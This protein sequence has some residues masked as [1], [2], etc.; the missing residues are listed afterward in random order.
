MGEAHKAAQRAA[1]HH[2]SLFRFA[3]ALGG[4]DQE[5]AME[6]VQQTYVEVLEGRADPLGAERPKAFLL[7][8]VRRVAASRRRRRSIWGRILR[9]EP[10]LTQAKPPDP[11]SSA[12]TSERRDLVR[13]ALAALPPRQLQVAAL[14]FAEDLT[15]EEAARVMG[16]SL[17]SARTHYHRAKQ[18]LARL[19]DKDDE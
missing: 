12:A 8:V 7:G 10:I 11:E 15:L 5:E 14:V 13:Q 4:R 1:E 19:L 18:R 16:V 17:G 9:L 6:V 2:E 3:L